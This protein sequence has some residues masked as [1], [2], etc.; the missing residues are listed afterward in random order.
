[1]TSFCPF[2]VPF[3]SLPLSDTLREIYENL[4]NENEML[5]EEKV[6]H[7]SREWNEF[8]MFLE[9]VLV[10][11]V[12]FVNK[13]CCYPFEKYFSVGIEFF[14]LPKISITEVRDFCV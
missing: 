10:L 6:A 2:F 13:L 12:A 8:F 9:A 3:H 4:E 11:E 1:M 14:F 7:N 5:T